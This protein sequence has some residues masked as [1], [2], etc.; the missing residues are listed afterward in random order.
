M[1]DNYKELL[2]AGSGEIAEKKSRFI[3]TM[4]PVKS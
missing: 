3:A 2:E 1:S 4:M